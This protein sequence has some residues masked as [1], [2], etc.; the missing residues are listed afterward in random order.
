[1]TQNSDEFLALLS[2]DIFMVENPVESASEDPSGD[3][4]LSLISDEIFMTTEQRNNNTDASNYDPND[5][6][7]ADNK[8]EPGE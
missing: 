2:D 4:F 3:D 6:I 8:N 7:T 5:N 1:M